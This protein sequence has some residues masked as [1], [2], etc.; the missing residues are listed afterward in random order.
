MQIVIL[1]NSSQDGPWAS[2]ATSSSRSSSR[3]QFLTRPSHSFTPRCTIFSRNMQQR[4][5]L[6]ALCAL[7]PPFSLA[8][9]L[10][11]RCR[12]ST[13]L[14]IKELARKASFTN[15][16]LRRR[17][18][19]LA[20]ATHT[21]IIIISSG[22]ATTGERCTDRTSNTAG[23]AHR[24]RLGL[25]RRPKTATVSLNFRVTPWYLMHTATNDG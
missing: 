9:P 17:A 15:N 21:Y 10:S 1:A 11:R 24:L 19:C 13:N 2:E 7:F 14:L 18:Q 3:G 12:G 5:W 8:T 25:E 22:R 23:S 20:N 6:W 16:K 4:L